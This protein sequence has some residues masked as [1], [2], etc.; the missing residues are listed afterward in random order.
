M[1]LD[2][3]VAFSEMSEGREKSGDGMVIQKNMDC[4]QLFT[5]LS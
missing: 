1:R 2:A 5:T 4:R 3:F